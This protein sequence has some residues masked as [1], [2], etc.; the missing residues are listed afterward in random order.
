MAHKKPRILIGLCEIAGYNGSL[1]S[2]F[3][4]LGVRADF[5]DL[6]CHAFA[7]QGTRVENPLVS[8]I[9][10]LDGMANS[11]RGAAARFPWLVLYYFCTALLCLWTLPRYDSYIFTFGRSF[12]RCYDLPLLKFLGKQVIFIYLGSDSRPPYLNRKSHELDVTAI[13]RQTRAVKLCVRRVE[14]WA[15][16]I[17][18]HPPTS[19]FHERK[20]VQ[21]MKMGIPTWFAPPPPSSAPGASE[22]VR[23]LHAPS[24]SEGKGTDRIREA[25][26]NLRKKGH[27]IDYVEITNRPNAEVLHELERCDFVVD[28][29]YSDTL[30]ARF[31][32]EA[33]FFGK[34]A[35]VGGYAQEKDLG[36]LT[37]LEIPPVH[38]CSPAQI[39]AAIEK[40]VVDE[41]Y[42]TDLGRRAKEFLG[43]QWSSRVVAE[44]FLRLI[45]NEAPTEWFFDPA[46]LR[47]LYGWGMPDELARQSLRRYLSQ[48]GE[49]A[50]C[51]DDKPELVRRFREFVDG[52]DRRC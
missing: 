8:L 14:R 39:E 15:D 27:R 23:I 9:R 32:S 21:F 52:G 20:V 12:L 18:N 33:A 25:I 42:R 48:G 44:R 1:Q 47:Y 7:Y 4:A 17:V 31:A 24:H 50:L 34:P 3:E 43:R 6:S 2:G 45:N 28:E 22:G 37:A 38:H 36:T 19:H 41:A 26:A 11:N 5:Y 16:Y 29:L 40:L 10:R 30:M 46:E 49:A 35:V 51:L 13:W